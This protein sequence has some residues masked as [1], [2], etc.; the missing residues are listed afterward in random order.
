MLTWQELYFIFRNIL[1]FGVVSAVW[2]ESLGWLTWQVNDT[3]YAINVFARWFFALAIL[4]TVFEFMTNYFTRINRALPQHGG[5]DGLPPPPPDGAPAVPMGD[6][7][8]IAFAG[9]GDAPPPPPGGAPARPM[10][11]DDD[12]DLDGHPPAPGPDGT[13]VMIL[14]HVSDGIR[15]FFGRVSLFVRNQAFVP[16]GAVVHAPAGP[17][18]AVVLQVVPNPVVLDPVAPAPAAPP[19]P[20]DG[21]N[22]L[23]PI[24]QHAYAEA[25]RAV[26][27][28]DRAN[29]AVA[30]IDQMEHNAQDLYDRVRTADHLA[31]QVVAAAGHRAD[32]TRVS[33]HQAADH[34]AAAG[35][36]ANA[37]TTSMQAANDASQEAVNSAQAA[38]NAAH[39][40]DLAQHA[41][42][43][44][45]NTARKNARESNELASQ[46]RRA[47]QEAIS[48]AVE[49]SNALL[50]LQCVVPAAVDGQAAAGPAAMDEQAAAGPAAMDE[51]AAAGPA[52]MDEQAAAG[53]AAMDGQ[54]AAGPAAMDGQAAA[55]PAAMDGQAAA[56]PAAVDGQAA[57]GPAA[58]DGQAVA[59]D[60]EDRADNDTGA[61]GGQ[62]GRR[63]RD[64]NGRFVRDGGNKRRRRN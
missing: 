48:A 63:R 6:D 59:M 41:T 19:A 4:Q 8:A 60:D 51:Q 34:A 25:D 28:A 38:N 18:R 45:A 57:A 14:Q 1:I 36:A 29:S 44:R 11:D 49:A 46:A 5:N 21:N 15:S 42:Q 22:Q 64:S 27:A 47:A 50:F 35:V 52:A 3:L 17:V 20:G 13:R 43:R 61:V 58:V 39:Q 31:R 7:D 55:G 33:A 12:D 62:S 53:P 16:P 30:R 56:G 23:D 26:Q 40:A 24:V 9:P 2:R 10:G 32:N 37:A 54:A